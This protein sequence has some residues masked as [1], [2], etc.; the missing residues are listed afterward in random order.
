MARRPLTLPEVAGQLGVHYMTAYRYV[1]TGRLPAKRV[2]GTWRVDPADLD[3][4]RKSARGTG[5]RRPTGVVP[6][7]LHLE[8]R[9]IA[10]DEPGAWEIIEAA[11][12]SGME[13]EAVL[14]EIISPTLR[15]IG[16]LWEQGKLSV[17][18][19]H[20]ASA[21]ATRLIS[22]LGARFGRRGHKRGTVIVAAPA[23]EM[24]SVP[25]AIAANLL[26]WH[27]FGVVEL[28]ADTPADALAE[29]A[30]GESDLVAVAIGCTSKNSPL[31]A[32][33]AI[34][35]VRQKV[36]QVPILLGGA[37]VTTAAQARRLGADMFTGSRADEI[38]H[39]LEAI[40]EAKSRV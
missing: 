26:R 28:G 18:D 16:E 40:V 8:T 24:H 38:V 20:R 25:I 14:L 39:A 32:R 27:G 7:R 31:A 11:L 34:A 22:R 21:V 6:A 23:G 3:K 10:S 4:M 15:S 30:V 5:E 36:P 2:A 12:G 1:R 35:A 13:P 19:E 37:A 33:R 9:L 17:A 29:A